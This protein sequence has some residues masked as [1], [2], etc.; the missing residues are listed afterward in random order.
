MLGVIDE[1]IMDFPS[2][3]GGCLSGYMEM[4]VT[5]GKQLGIFFKCPA[6]LN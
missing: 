6:K 4:L 1:A 5:F 2:L 3:V